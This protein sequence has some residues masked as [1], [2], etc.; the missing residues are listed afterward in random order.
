ML[1]AGSGGSRIPFPEHAQPPA[2]VAVS[3]GTRRPVMR[4]DRQEHLSAGIRSALRQSERPTSLHPRP[5]RRPRAASKGY[6]SPP[7]ESASA[8][9]PSARS[10]ESPDCWKAPVATTTRFASKRPSEVVMAKPGRPSLRQSLRTSTPVRTG[11][12]HFRAY[13]SRYA[14]TRSLPGKPSGSKPSNSRPGKRSCQAGPLAT[15]ESHRPDRQRS[16]MRSRSRTRCGTAFLLRCSLI[17]MPAWPAPTTSVSMKSSCPSRSGTP[18]GR[19][20]L[21]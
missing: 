13:A 4:A 5:I 7:N 17:A 1:P 2:I 11:A 6:G 10:A 21:Q 15:S 18:L 3:I 20:S 8:L 9:R 16:A 12:A 19:S 14:T